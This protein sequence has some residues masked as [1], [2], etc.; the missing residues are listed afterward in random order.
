MLKNH[1]SFAPTGFA[2][3]ITTIL[4]PT[5]G[6][7]EI[8]CA[9]GEAAPLFIYGYPCSEEVLNETAKRLYPH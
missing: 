9:C 4:G 1:R 3:P 2:P 7:E 5:L 6:K 8:L